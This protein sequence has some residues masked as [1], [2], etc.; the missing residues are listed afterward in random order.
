MKKKETALL[1]FR[2]IAFFFE[3]KNREPCKTFRP[4]PL[5]VDGTSTTRAK[6]EPAAFTNTAT[7]VTTTAIVDQARTSVDHVDQ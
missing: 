2:D 3:N 5:E 4:Q 7:T 6:S 1:T